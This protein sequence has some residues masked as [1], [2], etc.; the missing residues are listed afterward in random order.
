MRKIMLN[1]SLLGVEVKEAKM[2]IL[3]GMMSGDNSFKDKNL[4]RVYEL[5]KQ[6]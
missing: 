6:F 3:G 1:D 5:G 4:K 2:E